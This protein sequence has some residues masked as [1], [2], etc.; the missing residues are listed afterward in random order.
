MCLKIKNYYLNFFKKIHINKKIKKFIKYYLKIKNYYLK[1]LTAHL[2]FSTDGFVNTSFSQV[3][4]YSFVARVQSIFGVIF[5][6][7]GSNYTRG[8]GDFS[9]DPLPRQ[10]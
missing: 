8:R 5:E 6:K 10:F 1:T 4:N 2:N 9:F 3:A 7:A